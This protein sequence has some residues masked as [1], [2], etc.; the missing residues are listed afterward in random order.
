MR[1]A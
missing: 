1:T